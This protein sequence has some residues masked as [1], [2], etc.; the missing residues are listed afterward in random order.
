MPP[1]QTRPPLQQTAGTAGHHQVGGRY[2]TGLLGLRKDPFGQ[3]RIAQV[4]KTALTAAPGPTRRFSESGAGNPPQ[5]FGRRS[6][7]AGIKTKMAGLMMVDPPG[8]AGLQ[9]AFAKNP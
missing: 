7:M 4:K 2:R 5:Q 9:L 6:R 8:E 3:L 1:G